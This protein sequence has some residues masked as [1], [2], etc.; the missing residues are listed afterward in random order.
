MTIKDLRKF[1]V[2]Q[3]IGTGFSTNG[4]ILE[5][6]KSKKCQELWESISFLSDLEIFEIYG[7]IVL[8][9]HTAKKLNGTFMIRNFYDEVLKELTHTIKSKAT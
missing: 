4:T 1:I 3:Q 8:T 5:N 7:K 2:F 6:I 9:L